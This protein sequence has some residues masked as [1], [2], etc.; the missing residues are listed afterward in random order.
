M[1]GFSPY[2]APDVE[3]SDWPRTCLGLASKTVLRL[4]LPRPAYR[5]GSR[6]YEKAAVWGVPHRQ[7]AELCSW[8][9]SAAHLAFPCRNRRNRNSLITSIYFAPGLRQGIT[10]QFDREVLFSLYIVSLSLQRALRP[11]VQRATK[12]LAWFMWIFWSEKVALEG[13]ALSDRLKDTMR[14]GKASKSPH[15]PSPVVDHS[16]LCRDLR[17]REPKGHIQNYRAIQ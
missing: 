2:W 5:F 16:P 9:T 8:R 14:T 3:R 12:G 6:V 1:K 13:S 7:G 15:G 4:K 10:Q 17:L 11:T